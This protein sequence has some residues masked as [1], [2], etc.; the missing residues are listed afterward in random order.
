MNVDFPLEAEN[1][2]LPGIMLSGIKSQYEKSHFIDCYFIFFNG[3]QEDC[4]AD[5]Q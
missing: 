2:T 3:L 4:Y 5:Q 1:A